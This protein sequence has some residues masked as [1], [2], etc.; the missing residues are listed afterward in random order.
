MDSYKFGPNDVYVEGDLIFTVVHG[1]ASLEASQSYLAVAAEVLVKHGQVVML[2]DVT[3]GFGLSPETRRYT[4][5]WSKKHAIVASAIFGASAPTRAML[6][7]VTRAMNL[8]GGYQSNVRFMATE[9]E[10]RDWLDTYRL[11]AFRRKHPGI[12]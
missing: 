5:E 11:P 2:T 12:Y 1:V 9:A 8:I 3:E 10:A 6:L 7:L 4:T